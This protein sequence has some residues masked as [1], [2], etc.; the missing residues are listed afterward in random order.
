M[1]LRKLAKLAFAP[2]EKRE[3]KEETRQPCEPSRFPL[4]VTPVGLE[5]T[6]H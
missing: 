6:T 2:A 4:K 1:L 3:Q 5:P